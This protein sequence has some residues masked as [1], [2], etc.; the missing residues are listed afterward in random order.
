MSSYS[1]ARQYT[2]RLWEL[3][4]D[5]ILTEKEVVRA[6]LNYMSEAD[7]EDMAISEGFIEDEDEEEEE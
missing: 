1:S 5:G 2:N 6:C 7:V 4:E 3:M